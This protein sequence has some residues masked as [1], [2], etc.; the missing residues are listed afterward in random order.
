MEFRMNKKITTRVLI[1][2]ILASLLLWGWV[3]FDRW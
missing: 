3:A 1:T 2:L